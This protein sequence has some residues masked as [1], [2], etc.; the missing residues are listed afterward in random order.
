[1]AGT[2]RHEHSRS[3][4]QVGVAA[5]GSAGP[6]YQQYRKAQAYQ[7]AQEQ[8]GEVRVLVKD[9]VPTGDW[10]AREMRA[11]CVGYALDVLKGRV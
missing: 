7:D 5:E 2:G 4:E 6:A 1:M 10:F 11:A 9:G 8:H 3:A